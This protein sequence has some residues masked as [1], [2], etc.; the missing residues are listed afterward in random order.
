MKLICEFLL[1]NNN[2][3]NG[4]SKGEIYS[5]YWKFHSKL[6]NSEESTQ[7]DLSND[8]MSLLSSL[9]FYSNGEKM[10]NIFLKIAEEL[11]IYYALN[12]Y[13]YTANGLEAIE[14]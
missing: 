13:Y 3:V 8:E 12:G 1:S 5:V 11:R 2:N 7:L 14:F 6:S 9:L 10:N 4:N